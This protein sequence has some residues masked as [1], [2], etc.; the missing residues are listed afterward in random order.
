MHQQLIL[1]I[2][3]LKQE[4]PASIGDWANS[5]LNKMDI[6]YS[7]L[8]ATKDKWA[9]QRKSVYGPCVVQ[10]RSNKRLKLSCKPLWDSESRQVQRCRRPVWWGLNSEVQKIKWEDM[11]DSICRVCEEF[12]VVFLKDLLKGVPPIWMG[13]EFKIDL[14]PNTAPIHRPIYSSA[15]SS[16]RRQRRK[17]IRCSSMV[18]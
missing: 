17:S 5:V 9:I 13:Q 18:L 7:Y 8:T 12:A 11:L 3:W 4:N 15:R 1:G 2:P 6:L 14:D 16:F 10:R